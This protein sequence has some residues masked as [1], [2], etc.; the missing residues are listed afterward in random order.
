M[1]TISKVWPEWQVEKEI[2]Q[3]SYG[4][5]YRCVNELTR[6]HCA[7]K[8]ISIPRNKHEMSEVVSEKMTVEEAKEYYKEIA[9][10]LIKEI[11]ILKALKG[12]QNIVEIHE[13]QV[14]EK[15]T[16]IGWD[17]LIRMELL[18]D[19]NTYI[20]D[21]QL[22]EKDVIKLGA[23][24]GSAL[25]V[26]H[27]A[28]IIH[29]D[30]KPENILVDAEGNFKLSDFGVAKQMKKTQGSMS[31]KG[32]YN[33]MSPEVF[34]GKK[35]D[36][37]ADMYSLALVM[38]RL[39][40]NNRLPFLDPSKQIVRYSER[41][42][43]F[44]KRINGE[45]LPTIQG[46]SNELNSIILKACSFKPE[47][48]FNNIDDFNNQLSFLVKGQKVRRHIRKSTVKKVVVAVL[49]VTLITVSATVTAIIINKYKNYAEPIDEKENEIIEFENTISIE[50]TY[51]NAIINEISKDSIGGKYIY[52]DNDG[53]FLYDKN[54]NETSQVTD[55]KVPNAVFDGINVYYYGTH[56]EK[57]EYSDRTYEVKDYYVYD[58]ETKN[59]REIEP[60]NDI[61]QT[62]EFNDEI[63]SIDSNCYISKEGDSLTECNWDSDR[64]K[65]IG[66]KV[67]KTLV[68]DNYVL[69]STDTNSVV[70]SNG[71]QFGPVWVYDMN[72]E[73]KSLLTENGLLDE[74]VVCYRD[75]YFYL[76]EISNTQDSFEKIKS[77]EICS[78]NLN[79][80]S[81]FETKQQPEADFD[82]SKN[83]CA[84]ND[85]FAL[86]YNED[87]ETYYLWSYE[88]SSLIE[89][90]IAEELGELQQSFVNPEMSDRIILS[91][92]VD[93]SEE[94]YVVKEN[95]ELKYIGQTEALPEGVQKR[96][97]LIYTV[98]SE[99]EKI[100]KIYD[101]I[102]GENNGI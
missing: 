26:C 27:K 79:D 14:F 71:N 11:E 9:N 57:Y 33:Y 64:A 37:R 87:S 55:K 45:E 18:T 21:K 58:V 7:I 83:I 70:D 62:L 89:V 61:T 54:T 28:K 98:D 60:A 93:S 46:I 20:S 81:K 43:A 44:L 49:L 48:R 99:N 19:F 92:N 39:L 1:R 80:A 38:Y 82:L 73:N 86:I 91:F 72:N 17:I 41:Q 29:R 65:T 40:N 24:I 96:K 59:T 50:P 100:I 51:I 69:Y 63:I 31:V 35:C 22:T 68:F 3:G 42:S 66:Y 74:N 76:A 77:V 47:N 52:C 78:Y 53:V 23:D 88:D 4:T 6:E 75:G 67:T 85:R 102:Q 36:G 95:G 94:F 34:K 97:N 5:V 15:E 56:K 13:A 90:A 101:I 16:G 10:D 25:S 30:I 8:V 12:T 32:T 2:G 84:V